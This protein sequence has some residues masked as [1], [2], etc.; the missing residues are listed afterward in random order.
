MK[1]FL[2]LI[3]GLAVI[4]VGVVSFAAFESHIVKIRAHVESATYTTPYDIDFGTVFPQEAV[5]KWCGPH[6]GGEGTAL[7]EECFGPS[8]PPTDGKC[9]KIWLSTSFLAQGRVKDVT[10]DVYC[11]TPSPCKAG[12]AE[13]AGG[14]KP[15][16]ITPYIKLYDSDPK[17]GN[18]EVVTANLNC[19]PGE[20]PSL[21]ATGKL[22]TYGRDGDKVDWWD[23]TFC[24]PACRDNYNPDTD[25]GP[26]K[27]CEG[28]PGVVD[29]CNKGPDPDSYR[30]VNLAGDLKFQVT[31]FSYGCICPSGESDCTCE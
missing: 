11:E 17:D 30:W 18:D 27:G 4:L 21:W 16:P 1:R 23:M 8:C 2:L 20:K 6:D 29:N 22:H 19:V 14:T 3:A 28:L 7:S 10:Y 9:A 25:P 26:A 13:C 24:A 12:D 5:D 31:G 15:Q